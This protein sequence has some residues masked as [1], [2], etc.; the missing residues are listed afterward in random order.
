MKLLIPILVL[1]TVSVG[2]GSAEL[3]R[4]D[5]EKLITEHYQYPNVEVNMIHLPIGYASSYTWLIQEGYLLA[6]SSNFQLFVTDA[7]KPYS[8]GICGGDG[9]CFATN[10]RRLK[11]VSGIKYENPD[12][13]KATV[14]FI[15]E[16]YNI[17]P[18]GKQMKFIEGNTVSYAVTIERYDD[19]WRI[20]APKDK[21]YQ[22]SDFPN[23]KFSGN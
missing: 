21:N 5:A 14:E 8:V 15:V 18:F 3:N 13:T 17:T 4:K 7:A 1:L 19:G 22:E 23:V 20:T 9:E 11:E 2:C 16:R 6:H 10:M 12:K